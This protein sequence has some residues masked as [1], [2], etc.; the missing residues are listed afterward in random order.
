[1]LEKLGDF[2]YEIRHLAGA[3]NAAADYLSRHTT[4]AGQAPEFNKGRVSMKIRTIRSPNTPEDASFWKV[5]EATA[6]CETTKELIEAVKTGKSI[7]ELPAK[8]PGKDLVDIWNKMGVESTSKG[9]VLVINQKLYIPKDIRQ[10][11]LQYQHSIHMCA[12]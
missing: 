10:E 11:V 3:K 6:K 1:M 8:H 2:N 9:E 12:E 7:K 5:V 4:S